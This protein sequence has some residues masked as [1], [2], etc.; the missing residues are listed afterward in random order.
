MTWLRR[1]CTVQLV[2]LTLYCEHVKSNN[3]TSLSSLP[4]RVYVHLPRPLFWP[5][6]FSERHT[7]GSLA[8][9]CLLNAVIFLMRDTMGF[10]SFFF[11]RKHW[12]VVAKNSTDERELWEG[13]K[14]ID[15]GKKANTVIRGRRYFY[16]GSSLNLF[17]RTESCDPFSLKVWTYFNFHS[18]N[19]FQRI[20]WFFC[21]V[22]LTEY[23]LQRQNEA[24]KS[25][26]LWYNIWGS[27]KLTSVKME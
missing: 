15:V 1:W 22:S 12:P 2:G 17:S 21:W 18:H 27:V 13:T 5:S 20:N 25:V 19:F 16:F 4:N 6:P 8:A 26:Y 11:W 14:T 24:L 9:K 10:G 3:I 23:V 7:R